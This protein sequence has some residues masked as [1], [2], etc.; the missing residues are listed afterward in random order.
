LLLFV[1]NQ[2]QIFLKGLKKMPF[3]KKLKP[4]RLFQRFSI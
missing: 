4:Y 2:L 3:I 1:I